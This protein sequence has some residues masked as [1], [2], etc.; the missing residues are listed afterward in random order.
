M[1]WQWEEGDGGARYQI[2]DI[3]TM[4]IT[5]S[6]WRTHDLILH[7]PFLVCRLRIQQYYADVAILILLMLTVCP[8][9]YRPWSSGQN[10][11]WSLSALFPVFGRKCDKSVAEERLNGNKTPPSPAPARPQLGDG[12]QLVF[13]NSNFDINVCTMVFTKFE[14]VST[15]AFSFLEVSL[16]SSALALKNLWQDIT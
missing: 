1:L 2:P 6:G 10:R 5:F 4:D 14:I 11:V 8:L 9:A 16:F 7:K 3:T 15:S 12:W 13:S